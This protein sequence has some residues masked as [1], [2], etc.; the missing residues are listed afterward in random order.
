MSEFYHYQGVNNKLPKSQRMSRRIKESLTIKIVVAVE[1]IKFYK[2]MAVAVMPCGR[3]FG[4]RV[5]EVKL[6]QS[7]TRFITLDEF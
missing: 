3:D 2:V 7:I 5:K 4:T 6:V 1:Q